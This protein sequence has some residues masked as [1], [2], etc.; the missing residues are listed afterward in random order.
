M[1]GF[2]FGSVELAVHH[3]R[4]SRHHLDLIWAHHFLVSHAV[5]VAEFPRDHIADD[6][7]VAVA[8]SAE[9]FSGCDYILV[10]NPKTAK[11]GLLRVFIVCE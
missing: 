9:A 1:Y 4:S 7:H 8:V 5:F 2:S 11:A 3:A 10:Q 6:L